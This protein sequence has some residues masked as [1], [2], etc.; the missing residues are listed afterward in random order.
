MT[1]ILGGLAVIATLI[2]QVPDPYWP[3]TRGTYDAEVQGLQKAV[4]DLTA[5]ILCEKWS[6][7]LSVLLNI[8]EGSRSPDEDERIR[9]L[10]ARIDEPDNQCH[11]FDN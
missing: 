8:P 11:E 5:L 2:S 1:S 4:E 9:V 3:V 10:R 7:E 6:E